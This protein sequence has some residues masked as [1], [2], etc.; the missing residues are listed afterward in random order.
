MDEFEPISTVGELAPEAGRSPIARRLLYTATTAALTLILGLAVLDG[1]DVADVY[2]VDTATAEASGGGYELA[3]R[4]GTVTRPALATPFEIVVTHDGGFD[5]PITI[6]VDRAYL[7]MWDENGLVPAPS[8][9]TSDDEWVEWEFDPP[10]GDTLTVFFDARIE[11]AA[12]SG[13]AGRVAV[14]DDDRA[15]AEVRFET[16]V[17]P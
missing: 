14:L 8:A 4:Y 1:F 5:G 15:V 10:T 6:A 3:V 2:G 7:A 11:P 9:E 13:R 17:L 16:R 12:Q